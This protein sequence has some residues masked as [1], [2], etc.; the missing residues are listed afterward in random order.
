MDK[1]TQK[2]LRK[3]DQA[4]ATG[5]DLSPGDPLAKAA[6]EEIRRLLALLDAIIHNDH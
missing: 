2:L 4:G 3:L 6:A 5:L 1:S